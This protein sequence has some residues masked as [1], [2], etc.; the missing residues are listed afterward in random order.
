MSTSGM[1]RDVHSLIMLT[2]KDVAPPP[3]V[4]FEL[5]VGDARKRPRV[6]GFESLDLFFFFQSQ[7]AG[8]CFTAIEEEGDNKRLVQLNLLA[9]LNGIH[10][11]TR[12]RV[13]H[14][15]LGLFV[16]T[17]TGALYFAKAIN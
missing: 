13:F 12:Q 6:L 16:C 5:R 15:L 2:N 17:I 9:K 3:V 8:P 10:L 7:K 14:L 1:G 11:I 4:G